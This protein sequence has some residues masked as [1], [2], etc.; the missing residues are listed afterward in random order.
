MVYWLT[1]FT[2]IFCISGSVG[3]VKNTLAVLFVDKAMNQ[4]YPPNS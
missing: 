1:L 4:D 3:K 2:I